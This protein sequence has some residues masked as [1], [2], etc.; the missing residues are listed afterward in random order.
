MV[1]GDGE[2]VAEPARWP[3][4]VELA[5]REGVL[6]RSLLA[7][8]AAGAG[9]GQALVE[10]VGEGLLHR[11]VERGGRGGGLTDDLVAGQTQGDGEG[12]SVGIGVGG[13]RRTNPQGT[14]R[15]I[16]DEEAEDL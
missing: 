11:V 1:A 12:D 15:L 14:Q 8:V 13:L 4:L 10:Q 2:R 5:E 6:D 7:F 3:G 16:D 9:R